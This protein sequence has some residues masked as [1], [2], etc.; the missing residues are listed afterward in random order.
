MNEPVHRPDPERASGPEHARRPEAA[1]LHPPDPARRE[2]AQLT[3][4]AH[5]AAARTGKRFAD[6]AELHAFSTT[7]LERFW[8]LF[9]EWSGALVSGAP[10]PVCTSADVETAR[11]FPALRLSWT[12]NLLAVRSLDEENAVAIVACD[13]TGART[14]VTRAEL[15][16]QVRAVAAGLEAR[17]LREGDRVAA[18]ARNTLETVV[19]CLAVTSL[20]A[21]WSSV[22]PDMGLE[23]ALARFAP[24]GPKMLFVHRRTSLNGAKVEVQ[25]ATLVEGLPSLQAVVSLDSLDGPSG[26]G[27]ASFTLDALERDGVQAAADPTAPWR[28]FPFD[29]PLF[30]LFSSG[31]TGAP[32]GIVHGHGGTLVEHLKEH[33]LHCDLGPADRLCF[34]TSTGWMMWNWTV[35]ALA[36]GAAIVLYDGSVSHPERDSL[37]RVAE[38][39]RV[40][41]LGMSPAYLQY[42]LDAGVTRGA[43]ALPALREM[44]STGSVLGRHLHRWAKENVADVPLQSISGG[45]DLL[46]CFVMGSPWTSTYEGESGCVG[47][48]LDVR[49]WRAPASDLSGATGAKEGA[50]TAAA[51]IEREGSGELVCV[52]PFPSR[53]VGF[54][55]DP[56]GARFHGAY[57]SQ[58]AGVWTHGDLIEVAPRGSVRVVGRCDG[59]LK[60]RGIRI[61][62]SEIYD[63]LAAAVPEVAQ[64]MAVDEEAPR[65]PGGKR[66]VLFVTLKPGMTLDRPLTLRLKRALKERASAAHVPAAIVEVAELPTTFSGKLSE[67]AMQDA[68]NE[69]PVRNRAALRNPGAIDKA[70]EALR[71]LPLAS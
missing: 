59:T 65:E 48:A 27:M 51:G 40:T 24:L 6:F 36:A 1:V 52:R 29:Q 32:K 64:A 42:L 66:L 60:I 30:V 11:F 20:G 4:F 14:Q 61:G 35:S 44:H 38:R 45:T 39:E 25:V 12:E 28:R 16:R 62:P 23:A 7:D 50:T 43:G 21:T 37:L 63:V 31:T 3:D 41:V 5:F 26:S 15:R 9:L 13:E 70:I 67:A 71:R 10:Q 8:A 56:D 69:R 47:L 57:F 54:L 33:R 19:A 46:G 55:G 18:V 22:A 58:H 53:P 17:G 2:R 49:V 34:Q 68:L